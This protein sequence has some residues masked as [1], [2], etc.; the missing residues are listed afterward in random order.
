[1]YEQLE[2]SPGKMNRLFL[3]RNETLLGYLNYKICIRQSIRGD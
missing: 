2:L 3:R 1:V